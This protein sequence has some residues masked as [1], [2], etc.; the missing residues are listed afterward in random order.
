[1][2]GRDMVVPPH[3][4]WRVGCSQGA[5]ARTHKQ[6]DGGEGSLVGR[7][8]VVWAGAVGGGVLGGNTHWW[9]QV[10]K[11]GGEQN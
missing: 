8:V 5:N 11:A 2:L 1:M 9:R 6:R 10:P 7:T 4:A 3:S